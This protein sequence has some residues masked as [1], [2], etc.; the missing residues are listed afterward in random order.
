MDIRSEILDYIDRNETT[1]ALLITGKWGCG[2]SYL[3]KKI[4]EDQNNSK[5]NAIAI[6]SLFGL[7]SIGAINKRV[8]EEYFSFSAGV[9]GK[10]SRKISKTV[11]NV[12]KDGTAVAGIATNGNAALSA[13]SHGLSSV[14]NYDFFDFI[15]VKKTI[16]RD[17][18]AR[19][20]VIVFDDLERSNL[21]KKELLGAINEYIENKQIKV[22]IV[23]D[24]D[25]LK[26][27]EYKEYKEKLI[28]R[29]IRMNADYSTLIDSIIS[30][31]KEA[32]EG[33]ISFLKENAELLKQVFNESNAFNLRTLKTALADFE[34]VYSA[35]KETSIAT[36]NMKWALYTFTAEVYISRLPKKKEDS[37]DKVKASHFLSF[38]K[39]EE[40]FKNRGKNR[41]SFSSFTRW[42]NNGFWDKELF[43]RE[44]NSKYNQAES[45]PLERFLW[46]NFWNLQQEDI[47]IGLPMAVELAYK[48]ELPRDELITTL[49][50]IHYLRINSI[51]L[52]CTINY[53]ELEKGYKKRIEMIKKNI[54]TEPNHHTFTEN[55]Q[56]DPEAI[57]L[58][59]LI[60]KTDDI[61]Y[62]WN[63]RNELISFLNCKPTETGRR[64]RGL[65][66]EEFDDELLDIFEKRYSHACNADKR[67]YALA[68]LDMSFNSSTYSTKDNIAKTRNNFKK[69]I[70]WLNSQQSDDS[71]TML[72]NKSLVEKIK[73][74][75][76]MN[77]IEQL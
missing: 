27:D 1:G 64:I 71:I 48:G 56:I 50:N 55:S 7:D 66:L 5:K 13:V 49:K 47:A 44:L 68:L 36:D 32:E 33:Y 3:V 76:I 67:E 19:K 41:S 25:K 62:A 18:K 72:I 23:A 60:K 35:W 16:G 63:N 40:P 12:A 52:P 51:E 53:Q 39:E 73:Q 6:I 38:E 42:I 2:K 17:G 70:E 24:E 74:S 15:E 9:L 11:T 43:Y 77:G 37:E 4:A 30:N 45:T 46:C 54:I 61:L 59:G 58:N 69:L 28:S 20:F 26:D 29:T 57:T 34:R 31:Y 10:V 21:G 75:Q 22:I 65:Y 14:M 8:K